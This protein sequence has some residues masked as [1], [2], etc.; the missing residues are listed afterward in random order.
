MKRIKDYRTH[1]I[2]YSLLFFVLLSAI[3]IRYQGIEFGLPLAPH[4][5][6]LLIINKASSI[7]KNADCNPHFFNYP[8]LYIYMQSALIKAHYEVG[9]I[10]GKEYSFN[11]IDRSTT[12]VTGRLL[13]LILSLGTICTV[14][15]IGTLLFDRMT[16]LLSTL[17]IA[18]SFL[19]ITHSYVATVDS[20][21]VFWA[22]LSFLMSAVIFLNGPKLRYYILNGIFI[23]LAIGTKYTAFIA[24]V[25]LI[26]SHLYRH[27]FSIRKIFDRK[28][29]L[30][31]LVLTLA[32]I[33]STPYAIFD[34]QK[35]YTD[36][37]WEAKHYS[38]TGHPGHEAES[39]S[40]RAY[41]SCLLNGFGLIPIMISFLGIVR[42]LWNKK[43]TACL[44]LLFP[45]SFFIFVGS[46]KVYFERNMLIA[47]PFLSI[48]AGYC[49][50][51]IL[52]SL[53]EHAKRC[54]IKI[55]E[56]QFPTLIGEKNFY[57]S[58][59]LVTFVLAAAYGIYSQGLKSYEYTKKIS[60]PNTI[61]VSTKWIENN[62]PPGSKIALDY[63]T[64]RPDKTVFKLD[65]AGLC[66]LAKTRNLELYDYLVAS[67]GDYGR[68]FMKKEEKYETVIKNY[69]GI[70]T[71]YT[72]IQEF[73]ANDIDMTGPTIKIFK[74][75]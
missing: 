25:P 65:Y 58:L 34:F 29:I 62:I 8:S 52:P 68:F 24:V 39:T 49:M 64:P 10:S 35:F 54:A 4:P 32:F 60:L 2:F 66:G 55:R 27:S 31:F 45:L 3:C 70:F 11:A 5:D 38:E 59:I 47:I 44:L 56:K 73:T 67:S 16:G 36:I 19:H 9:K 61:W 33:I 50:A 46:Y 7:V 12:F 1:G 26:Y 43:L 17:F 37:L 69:E 74:V 51:A 13:T 75:N 57:L 23:G 42:L 53:F 41:S 30:A 71:R 20:P 63:Y 14:Y 6:E 22:M 40:Y 72:L 15:V 48:F 21:M 18:F 28:L